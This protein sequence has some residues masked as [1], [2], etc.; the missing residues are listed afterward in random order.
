MMQAETTTRR[1]DWNREAVYAV[2]ELITK[3]YQ[4][5][6]RFVGELSWLWDNMPEPPATATVGRPMAEDLFD[7]AGQD[8]RR[9]PGR[10][11]QDF[12]RHYH[13]L[14]EGVVSYLGA[15]NAW[16]ERVNRVAAEYGLAPAP[17][18]CGVVVDMAQGYG[19][20]SQRALGKNDVEEPWLEAYFWAMHSIPQQKVDVP[21]PRGIRVQAGMT[22]AQVAAE[23]KREAAETWAYFYAMN[24]AL[25]ED[26]R[27]HARSVNL[28]RDVR[29]FYERVTP[30]HRTPRE[31]FK[32]DNV[33]ERAVQDA[34]SG[35]S[36][37]INLPLPKGPPR[38]RKKTRRDG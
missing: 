20:R 29:W 28:E 22:R 36:R 1:Y 5:D 31:I 26:P 4:R 25:V 7:F 32:R 15:G 2:L 27:W 6:A 18:G 3:H 8:D 14:W 34:I 10:G 12:E 24:Q 23:L 30:P 33:G 13:E 11:I 21:H 16:V 9:L 37:L 38:G 35:V 19:L 17:W